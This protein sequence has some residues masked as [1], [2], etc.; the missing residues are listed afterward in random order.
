[1]LN[2]LTKLKFGIKKL[3]LIKK[4]N[5]AQNYGLHKIETTLVMVGLSLEKLAGLEKSL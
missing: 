5:V 3:M 2:V 4:K 1:M